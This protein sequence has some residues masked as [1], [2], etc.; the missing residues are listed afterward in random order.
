VSGICVVKV[1]G[2]LMRSGAAVRL[3]RAWPIRPGFH[4]V[5]VSG[6]GAFADAVRIAQQD[7]GFADA[8]AHRLALVAME[9]SARAL[10]SS[11]PGFECASTPAEFE[12]AWSNGHTPIWMPVALAASAPDIPASWDVT[13]DSLAAWI[14]G[15]VDATELLVVK[16]CAVPEP[17]ECDA[18]ALAAAG[19]VDP[20]FPRYVEGKRFRWEIVSGVDAAL[21]RLA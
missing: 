12:S 4:Q 18:R 5:V 2:S 16:S 10:A 19:I 13:S 17:L 9:M 11:A 21:A 7:L 14:A 6:G 20:C 8:T 3:L 1:G 15:H